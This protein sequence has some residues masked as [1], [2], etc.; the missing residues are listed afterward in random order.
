[1]GRRVMADAGQF[2]GTVTAQDADAHHA[3]ILGQAA[4]YDLREQVRIDVSATDDHRDV[5][6]F[7]P[8]DLIEEDGRQRGRASAFDEGFFDFEQFQDRAGDLV[9][10]DGDD[11]VHVASRDFDCALARALDRQAVG[12]GRLRGDFRDRAPAQR[13]F[14]AGVI[15]RFDAD[16]ACVRTLLF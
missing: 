7:D 2:A 10:A 5:L 16:D 4:L 14:H 13:R 6:D 9:F 8:F 3:P 12:D 15:F 11:V 1:Y